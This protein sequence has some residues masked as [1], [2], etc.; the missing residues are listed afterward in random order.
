[1]TAGSQ[2]AWDGEGAALTFVN[3]IGRHLPSVPMTHCLVPDQR[4][5]LWQFRWLLLGD[6]GFKWKSWLSKI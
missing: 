3:A 2:E 1:M 4:G 6:H 5:Q